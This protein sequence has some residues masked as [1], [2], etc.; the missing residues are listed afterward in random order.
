M[1]KVL[2]MSVILGTMYQQDVIKTKGG[3]DLTIGFLGHSSLVMVVDNKVIYI[4]P[5]AMF[6]DYT[7]APK[8]DV[9]L[10]THHHDDHLDATLI[11][12]L[13]KEGTQIIGNVKSVNALGKGYGLRNEETSTVG[14][15]LFIEAVAAYNTTEGHKDFHPSGGRDNGYVLTIDGTRIYVA[16]D[17]EPTPEMLALKD[18]DIAFLPVNQPYTMTVE[19]AVMAAKAIKPKI[20]YPYHTGQTEFKTDLDMLVSQLKGSGIDVRVRPME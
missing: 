14:D 18:I 5:V 10:L 6:A 12:K 4:D 7:A 3:E 1:L 15:Y 8:A 2:L 17:T 19:Q 13:C 20:F 9:I 16:G 11:D